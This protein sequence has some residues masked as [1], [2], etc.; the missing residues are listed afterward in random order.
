VIVTTSWLHAQAYTELR[1]D[2]HPVVVMAARDIVDVLRSHGIS[3]AGGK[4]I[5]LERNDVAT[6]PLGLVP[7][8]PE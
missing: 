3:R 7:W 2:G 6:P 5:G 4:V 1:A 8:E